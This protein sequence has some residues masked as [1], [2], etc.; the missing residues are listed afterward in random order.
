VFVEGERD[1]LG[2]VGEPVVEAEEKDQDVVLFGEM[3][4]EKRAA[5]RR[6]W[7]DANNHA[8]FWAGL[9]RER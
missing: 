6:E 7:W 5:G 2:L 4:T 3:E 8:G 1:G 9:P